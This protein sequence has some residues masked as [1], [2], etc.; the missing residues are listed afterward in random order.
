[1]LHAGVGFGELALLSPD[2]RRNATILAA[3]RTHL[4]VIDR[5]TYVESLQVCSAIDLLVYLLWHGCVSNLDYLAP[6]HVVPAIQ[7]RSRRVRSLPRL[8]NRF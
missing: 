5:A 2:C 4:I 6:S 7:S 1:M 8:Q 3:E